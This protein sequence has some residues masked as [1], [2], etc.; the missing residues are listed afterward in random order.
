MYFW[1]TKQQQEVDLVEENNGIIT[2]FE[3]KWKAK[4]KLKLPKTFVNAYNATEEIID[5]SNF[6]KFVSN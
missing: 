3:F 4:K 5:R 6:R 1:R 2:G